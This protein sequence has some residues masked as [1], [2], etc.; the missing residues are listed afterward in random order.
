MVLLD[1]QNNSLCFV[2]FSVPA[3]TNIDIKERERRA[4]DIELIG[5]LYPEG[6]VHF[7]VPI[8]GVLGGGV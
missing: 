6:A 7:V 4:K 2:E 1:R 3:E 8:I 5:R